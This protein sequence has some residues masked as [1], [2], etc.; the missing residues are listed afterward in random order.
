MHPGRKSKGVKA[1]FT[2]DS[3]ARRQAIAGGLRTQIDHSYNTPGVQGQYE[4]GDDLKKDALRQAQLDK[5]RAAQDKAWAA[6]SSE[7]QG[8]PSPP[9][10]PKQTASACAPPPAKGRA[11][12]QPLPPQPVQ[13]PPRPAEETAAASSTAMSSRITAAVVTAAE[14]MHGASNGGG[15]D[16]PSKDTGL[17]ESHCVREFASDSDSTI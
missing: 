10:Q 4:T 2:E 16:P 8:P 5:A 1:D 3:D 9:A 14:D 13:E 6:S 11:S 17:A 15:R 7:Q 12:W